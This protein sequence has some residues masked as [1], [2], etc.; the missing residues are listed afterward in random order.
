[1]FHD[2][3]KASAGADHDEVGADLLEGLLSD[4]LV[5]LVRHH[6][7]LL[8]EPGRTRRRLRGTVGLSELELLRRCDVAGRDPLAHVIDLD[9]AFDLVAAE[10]TRDADS[11]SVIANRSPLTTPVKHGQ[12]K[13]GH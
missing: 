2:V 13:E 3:G 12:R 9:D 6:L 7:C 1:M 10:L 5:W 8:R 4:H 11:S